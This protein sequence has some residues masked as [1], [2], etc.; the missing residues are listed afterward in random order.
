MSSCSAVNTCAIPWLT[1][2]QFEI[3]MYSESSSKTAV[4]DLVRS[5]ITS[6]LRAKFQQLGPALMDTHA[7]G[8][9]FLLPS[10]SLANHTIDLQH[11]AG[12]QTS[13]TPTKVY[14]SSSVTKQGDE[15]NSSSAVSTSTQAGNGPAVNVTSLSDQQEFRCDAPMLF[16]ILTDPQRIA[17]FTRAPPKTFEGARPGGKFEIFGGNVSGEYV[18]LSEPTKIVQKWRLAQWPQGHYSTLNI[19]F[20]QNNVDAVTIMRVDWAGVPVGEEEATK[21]NW[22]NYYVRSMKQTFGIGSIL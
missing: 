20:E 13:F 8:T 4:K 11:A 10:Q 22:E 15:P 1:P 16:H 9:Y 14:S 18:E 19:A 21:R 5:Q 12:H 6:Q 7:K 2:A 17:A 3:E